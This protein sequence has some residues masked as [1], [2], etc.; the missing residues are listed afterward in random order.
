VVTLP[1]LRAW[2]CKLKPASLRFKTADDDEWQAQAIVGNPGTTAWKR[3]AEAVL[4]AEAV[5]VQALSRDGAVLDTLV[6]AEEAEEEAR[7][8][9]APAKEIAALALIAAEVRK[10]ATEGYTAGADA[11]SR[12]QDNLVQVVNI[13]TTQWSSTMNAL[14]NVSQQLARAIRATGGETEG[15]E[16]DLQGPMQ[17]MMGMAMMR[18][19]GMGI[20]PTPDGTTTPPK[21]N[22]AKTK[23]GK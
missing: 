20:N 13:L 8:V 12:G 19:M 3:T 10:A 22:G 21:T 18:M 15:P 4:K 5:R 9:T 16:D 1:E 11:A 2:I 17:Q 14:H 23:E 7:A 6:L